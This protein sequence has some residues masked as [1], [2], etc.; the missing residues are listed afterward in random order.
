MTIDHEELAGN[1]SM[2]D[3]E[4]I[5]LHQNNKALLKLQEK[6]ES[7][8]SD[9][10][11]LVSQY[12]VNQYVEQKL[13]VMPGL[14]VT[15]RSLSPFAV[16]ES[17]DFADEKRRESSNVLYARTLARRRLAHA[18]ISMNGNR[19]SSVQLDGNPLDM[20]GSGLDY[21][22]EVKKRADEV[23]AKLEMIGLSDK[24]SETFGVWEKVV[25]NRMNNIEDISEALK[26][27]TRG[28]KTE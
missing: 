24:I 25:F 3:V 20:I 7:Q 26:N 11:T 10:T 12:T 16:D 5:K 8:C 28:S 6:I 23:Y 21:K 14:T 9:M 18:L 1:L 15:L 17:I 13:E 4:V 2:Q 19:L 27:S 22:E